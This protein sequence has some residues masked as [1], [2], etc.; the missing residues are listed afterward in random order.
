MPGGAAGLQ[1]Q[2]GGRKVPGGFDSLPSPPG[3]VYYIRRLQFALRVVSCTE[4]ALSHLFGGRRTP[5]LRGSTQSRILPQI[6]NGL[7]AERVSHSKFWSGRPGSNRRRP[8]WEAGFL[9]PYYARSQNVSEE[10][11]RNRRD[12]VSPSGERFAVRQG[13]EKAPHS[14]MRGKTGKSLKWILN[15]V[16]K[17]K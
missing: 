2:S 13:R 15:R 3:N 10:F 8:A 11:I 6:K 12:L 4:P 7:H 1:N 17:E 16:R 5:D 9:P 14:T